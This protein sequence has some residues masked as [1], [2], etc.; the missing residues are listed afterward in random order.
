MCSSMHCHASMFLIH[1]T[2]GLQGMELPKSDETSAVLEIDSLRQDVQHR[3]EEIIR[4][5]GL[6]K[7]KEE[8]KG[9]RG[10]G[11]GGGGGG[12]GGE[13]GESCRVEVEASDMRAKL[14]EEKDKKMKAEEELKNL[15]VCGIWL[16]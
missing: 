9:N 5:A 7:T 12:G 3:D 2:F 10:G 13:E 6:L 16:P 1:C 8:V 11:I 15:Q 4:L 14:E